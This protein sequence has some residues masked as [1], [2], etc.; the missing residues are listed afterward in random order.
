[1]DMHAAYREVGSFRAAAQICGTTPKTVKRS[2]EAAKLVESG[3]VPGEVRHN[4]DGVADLVAESVARTKGRISAKRLL[5]TAEAAGYKGS[6]RNFRRLVAEVKDTWKSKNHRGRRPGVWAPGDMVVFDWGQI[7][8]LFVFSAVVA[9][10]RFRFVYFTDNLGAEATMGALAEC[11]ETIGGVPKT[12]LTDR[13]GCL[14]GGTVAGLVI[15]TPA[16]VRFAT[17]YRFHPDF[18]EGAD[19]ESKGLVENLVGYVKSDLMIPEALTVAD[20]VTANAKGKLWC[21]EVNSVMHSEI[22]AIPAERLVTERE[23]F[24]DLPSLRAAIGKTVTRKVDKLSCVRFGSARYSVT[25]PPCDTMPLPRSLEVCGGGRRTGPTRS[26]YE[27]Q[28]YT[29]C[30]RPSPEISR[31][32]NRGMRRRALVSDHTVESSSPRPRAETQTRR[33]K[34]FAGIDSA[35]VHHDYACRT[36]ADGS[37][38]SSVLRRGPRTSRAG[39]PAWHLWRS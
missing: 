19:P 33:F 4:Y 5:P 27:G 2:V 21:E 11:F 30:L 26:P 20:L 9:W 1:M 18:C 32:G 29:A 35:S 24:S 13:M 36:T 25:G 17:H 14:K 28:R 31:T 38:P 22:C 7:G 37:W 3:A 6:P 39:P 10:S 34:L 16:Y 15:P 8:A 23:L 12:A